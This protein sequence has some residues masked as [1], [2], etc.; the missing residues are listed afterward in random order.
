MTAVSA[1]RSAHAVAASDEA[2]N[3]YSVQHG[4]SLSAIAQ[5]F[6]VSLAALEAANP[7]IAN[8]DRIYPGDE[9]HL[10]SGASD[11]GSTPAAPTG[12]A[13]PAAG[14]AGPAS[15]F[16]I[17]QNG[18]QMIE[19]FEGYSA[20]AYPDPGTGGAPW[21]IGYGHTKGVQPGQTITRAQ[22]EQFLKEDLAWAQD[23][24]RNN[25]HVPLNQNQFDA[26]V[27]LTYNL[28]ANGYPGLL[29][30]LNAGDYKGA[31]AMFGEYVHAGGHVLQGLV[32]RRAKE[33]A[34]FGSDAPD[35]GNPPAPPSPPSPPGGSHDYTVQSGDTLSG[36]AAR[37]GVSLQALE[38]ANPQ[39]RDFNHIY[40]G[41]V[42]H[43]P[44]G[45]GSASSG[46]SYT[47]RSGDTLS[48]IASS[49]GVS[50]SALLA[51]NPQISNPNRIYP[52][53]VIHLPGGGSA[54]SAPASRDYTVRSGDTMSAIASRHGVSLSAL[55][56]ANPQIANPN[57]IYPGQVVHIPGAGGAQSTGG[58]QGTGGVH[59]SSG[60]S[61]SKAV[62][63]ARQFLGR[64]ASE[65]KRSGALPMNPNVSSDECCA[66]FVSAVLQKAGLLDRH[67]DLVSGSSRT[68][69]GAAG[70]IGRI[71]KDRGWKVVDAAHARPGDVCILNNGGHV[72]LVASN[73]G[74]T[75][76]LIGSNN[77]NRNGTQQVGYGHPYGGAWYLT[78]P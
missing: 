26:L 68:G 24:V 23:A 67:T 74:G 71:L 57:R 38:A 35:G 19:G 78:P 73:N 16:S 15:G 34:L 44:G 12:G 9:I 29:A 76:Q 31:Q 45:G 58:T 42:I 8:P 6:G 55:L 22:A 53:Q 47:V 20:T 25:V 69:Q 39:I 10:P 30:K 56:S 1:V 52:G 27:S 3:T 48:G 50:L 11:G 62:D 66:N 33:A 60:A 7:Q 65:L 41:Q 5:R 37:Q 46:G 72:E 75:I 43:L 32:N 64:D 36:I 49:H 2:A 61:G 4:D 54:S 59:G 28:G 77:T 70:S 13:Q 40:P 18:V 14:K 63:I 51:A 17:S 21:T